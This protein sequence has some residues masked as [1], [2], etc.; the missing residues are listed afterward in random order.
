MGV[1]F[2]LTKMMP[3]KMK[4]RIFH[5]MGVRFRLTKMMLGGD[6]DKN[7][8]RMHFHRANAK[9]ISFIAAAIQYERHIVSATHDDSRV[10]HKLDEIGNNANIGIR[11]FTT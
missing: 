2:R 10:F 8:P 5:L 4:N 9:S 7:I 3:S 1:R 6:A 11:F